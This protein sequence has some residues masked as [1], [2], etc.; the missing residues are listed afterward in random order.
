MKKFSYLIFLPLIILN[1]YG[2]DKTGRENISN[3]K[4]EKIN[5]IID[6]AGG[7]HNASNIGLFFENRGKLYPRRLSQGPSGEFPI[8]SGHHYIYRLNPIVG[9]PNNVIQGRYTT[10]EEWEAASGYHNTDSAQ[11]AFSD[12]PYTWNKKLG[13]PVKDADGN[14]VFKSDQDSYCVYND[15]ANTKNILGIQVTQIGYAYGVQFAYNMIFYTYKITNTSNNTYKGMYFLLYMDCDVGDADG[16]APEYEDDLV[17]IDK[18]RNM[19]YMYDSKGYS[20]DWGTKTGYMGVVFLKTP[21]VGGIELGMTDAHYNLYNDDIDVDSIQYGIMSSS[22]SLYNSAIGGRYFHVTSNQNIHFDD[23]SQLPSSGGDLLVNASTG[24]YDLNPGDTLIFY[25]AL[26]AGEDLPGLFTSVEQA[27]N[28]VKANFELPKPPGNPTLN[29]VPSDNKA[30]LFWDD[31]AEHSVD[32]FSGEQDFEGYRI[33]KSRDKGI[34]WEK[35]ADFDVKDNVGSNSGIQYSYTDTTDINGFEYW[36][37]ITA[38]DRG[39]EQIPSLESPKGNTL[40]SINTISIIPRSNAI[41]RTPVSAFNVE[42]FGPGNSNYQLDINPIDN[43]ELKGNEYEISF[44][45]LT[46]I[47]NGNCKTSVSV[48]INDSSKTKPYKYGISFSSSSTVDILNITTGETIGRTGLGYPSG[49]RSFPLASE[50]ITIKLIDEPGTPVDFLPETGDL[51]SVDFSIQG[52][53][54]G[55][56]TVIYPRP[57][58][59]G[60]AQATSDGVLFNLTP[61]QIINS[62]SRIGG[63]DNINFVFTV[64]NESTVQNNLYLISTLENGFDANGEGFVNILIKNSSLDTIKVID[65][66][67]DQS[68]FEFNGIEGK[69]EFTSSKPPSP[70]NIFSVETAKPILPNI[71]DKYK[72]SIKGSSVDNVAV[73]NDLNKI[74]VVPNPYIVSSLYEPELSQL[75]SE[76]L[77]QIQFI[78][79]PSDC[80]I[81]IFSV[82]ADK[83]KTLEHHSQSGTETWD[84]RSESGREVAPGVYIY[85][86]KT[87]QSQYME[88]FAIIK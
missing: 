36:Y 81:Y 33:Y 46:K 30:I 65:S 5:S 25:T 78:N 80:T 14:P 13:W 31:K 44:S 62:I 67:F 32:K 58:S 47:D 49:G 16:G 55:A 7:T 2:Q 56:D 82:N 24:P 37:T 38:Y 1:I 57:F 64:I 76:P 63:T 40:Q 88:R 3:Q 6:R 48:Q 68:S 20:K 15:S 28:T 72:F 70:G 27:N 34:N 11:I 17:G 42:H 4:L 45:Y 75:R 59:T 19:V 52:V 54:N 8:N 77:R 69:I 84:L 12:K 26:V 51:I 61:P 79:L 66:L 53:K 50:G 86:V 73:T 43:D 9:F 10:D 35:I 18:S 71:Q 39:S 60:Q 22:H 23:P 83:V 85:I 74:R 87:L 41:G 21:E 29:G